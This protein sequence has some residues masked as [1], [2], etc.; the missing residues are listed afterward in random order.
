MISLSPAFRALVGF[1]PPKALAQRIQ[2]WEEAGLD[3][4]TAEGARHLAGMSTRE[5]VEWIVFEEEAVRR[6][7]SG[8]SEWALGEIASPLDDVTAA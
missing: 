3:G 7:V 1:H 5:C 6:C 4:G 2:R 8:V